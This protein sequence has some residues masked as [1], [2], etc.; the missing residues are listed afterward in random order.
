MSQWQSNQQG[1]ASEQADDTGQASPGVDHGP[2]K[3]GTQPQQWAEGD[4]PHW[5]N[6]PTPGTNDRK[7]SPPSD[8]EQSS[9]APAKPA[10]QDWLNS[11]A[12]DKWTNEKKWS[13]NPSKK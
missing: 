12:P 11:N 6:K 4:A 7:E 8:D 2:D 1:T 13:D 5:N 10:Q 9:P 3:S